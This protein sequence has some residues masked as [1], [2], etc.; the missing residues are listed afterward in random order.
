MTMIKNTLGREIPLEMNGETLKPFDGA[1]KHT[2]LIRQDK[3]NRQLPRLNKMVE[4]IEQAVMKSELKDGMTVSFHH[5]FRSGDF[6]LNMVMDV[7]TNLGIKNLTVA[8]SSLTPAHDELIR[9]IEKGTVTRLITSGV[10]GKL[11]EFISAGKMETPVLFHSHGGRARAIEVGQIKIDIAFLGVPSCDVYGNANGYS[12]PSACGS[13]GYAI[14][15]AKHAETVVFLTDYIAEYPNTPF[16]ID[17]DM[18]DFIVKVDSVGN[19]EK[20]STGATRITKDPRDLLIAQN[21]ADLIAASPYFEDGFSMQTGSGGA[22]LATTRYLTEHMEN[23]KIKCS[24]ALGGI[25]AQMVKMHEDGFIKRLLDVQSFDQEA[26]RSIG[27]NRLHTEIDASYY[28]NPLNKGCAVNKLNVVI[29]S[30]LEI[31]LDF[32]VNVLTG[33][34]GVIMGASGGHS[35]TAVG[36]GFSI[37]VAP[38]IRGRTSTLTEKVITVV[39]P[40]ESVDAFV[41]DRGIAI[42]PR[43]KDLIEHFKDY[44]LPFYTMKELLDKAERL[45]GKPDPIE[46]TDKIVGL[47]E[48]RDGTII[49]TVRQVKALD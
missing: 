33:S 28:A 10:R 49:D 8:S 46:F 17:Q 47:V 27:Q 39:T 48:Y 34:D 35:D 2:P 24:W 6:V 32:N 7:I 44:R 12:G 15:D 37:I 3:G 9:H 40:G 25:T 18:V 22:A 26:I 31:D 36:S 38:L 11:A 1:F 20:I 5:H 30:A 43:R 14:V 13:L 23:K 29:L 45:V 16:S 19:P 41:S 4:T 21:A 42:N